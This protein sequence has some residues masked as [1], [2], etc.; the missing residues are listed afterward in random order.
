MQITHTIDNATFIVNLHEGNEDEPGMVGI[1]TFWEI[2]RKQLAEVY[3][4]SEFNLNFWAGD[5]TQDLDFD[6]EC[7]DEDDEVSADADSLIIFAAAASQL[8][9]AEYKL[10]YH[11]SGYW[12]FHDM[13]HAEYD[14][15]DGSDLYINED[16][17][18]RA[19]PMGAKLA[20]LADIPFSEIIGELSKVR[21]E[22]HERFGFD[23]D[24][25]EKF[26]ESV[27]VTVSE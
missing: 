13:V 5:T 18:M 1:G 22:F 14:S 9:P 21:P 3:K 6:P 25:I 16:A 20:A 4:A 24:A 2:K 23:F 15:G 19:L 10:D 26:L 17:E 27:T 7:D 11:G 12:F 8:A